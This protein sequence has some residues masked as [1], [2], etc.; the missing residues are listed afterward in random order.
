MILRA[1]IGVCRRLGLA[2]AVIALLNAPALARERILLFKSD[3][4]IGSDGTLRVTETIRVMAEGKEIRRGILRDFPTKYSTPQGL[5]QNVGFRLI[6]VSR[7]GAVESHSVEDISNGKRIRIGSRDVMLRK[8][9]HE[10]RI[11]Y[12]TT[13]QLGFFADYD[14]LYWNASG[15]GWTFSIDSIEA[16]ITLPPGGKTVQLDAYT[17]AMGDTGKDYKVHNLANG[18]IL[19][20][21]TK[22]MP[23]GSGLTVAVAFPKGLVPEPT[24][25]DKLYLLLHDNQSLVYL[26][27][28]LLIVA[29]FYIAAWLMFGRDRRQETVIPLFKPPEGFTPAAIRFIY[30]MAY[31]PK[32]MTVAIVN[33]AVKGAVEI[34]DDDGS[35]QLQLHEGDT[36]KLHKR[37]E[38]LLFGLLGHTGQVTISQ[39]NHVRLGKAKR[40]LRDDLDAEYD[41]VIFLKNRWLFLFGAGFSILVLAVSL[42][43]GGADPGI[44]FMLV[45]LTGWIGGVGAMMYKLLRHWRMALNSLPQM[46][47]MLIGVVFLLPFMF[48]PIGVMFG[49]GETD[50]LP[51]FAGV[52]LMALI[53]ILFF[54]L[55]KA[56]T[57]AGREVLAEIEGFRMY[58]MAAEK[59]R[60]D[61]LHPPKRTPELFEKYLPYALALDVENEWGDQFSGVLA[62]AAERGATYSP[63]WY[64]GRSYDRFDAGSFSSNLGSGFSS[65]TAAAATAPGNSS[66]GGSSGG[67]SSGGG[68]G[69][70]GGSG[71]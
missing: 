43:L 61:F 54:H 13:R 64:H 65:A 23:P 22:P 44:I 27:V 9:V 36:G 7:D 3:V 6:S 47:G 66:S 5:N 39:T 48:A 62:A 56:P 42:L 68:G 63:R 14:E 41:A 46:I 33:L 71:W 10:Y 35:Y 37:E 40:Q 55:L 20:T 29:G 25:E 21:T 31:D 15:H 57:A 50:L 58:L 16:L 34:V 26:Y 1:G 45:W 18:Q 28:G 59:E 53:N 2:I 4:R 70:G 19:F 67:G 30:R 49:F 12:E 24:A 69:G 8:G 11:A 17:G 38:R 60:L 32:T 52:A 51:L